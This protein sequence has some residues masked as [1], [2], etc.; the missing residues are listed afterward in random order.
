M[1]PSERLTAAAEVVATWPEPYAAPLAELLLAE[2]RHA[3]E[4]EQE[5]AAAGWDRYPPGS[6][7]VALA[8]RVLEDQQRRQMLDTVGRGLAGRR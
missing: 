2:A 4:L 8:K 6:C 3:A 1:T 7:L 5:S